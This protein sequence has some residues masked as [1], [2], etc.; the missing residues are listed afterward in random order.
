MRGFI[1]GAIVMMAFTEYQRYKM[2]ASYEE[3]NRKNRE[4]ADALYRK[5]KTS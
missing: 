1:V 5:F 3:M 2:T 4:M